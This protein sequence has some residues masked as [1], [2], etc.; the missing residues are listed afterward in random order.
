MR[1]GAPSILLLL[2]AVAGCRTERAAPPHAELLV[3]AGDSTY[4]IST[5]PQGL[6]SRGSPI[7]LARFGGRFYEVYVVD[8]DRSYT[9]AEVVAQQVWRR[10]LITNDS[11]LVFRDTTILGLER[12]YAR[13]HPD[14]RRLDPDESLGDMPHVSATSRFDLLD[15]FGPFMSYDYTADL[16]VTAGDEWHFARRG[17]LDLRDGGDASLATLFG[18]SVARSLRKE[19]S[20]LFSQ[21]LDSVL[22]SNDARAREAG[23]AAWRSLHQHQGPDGR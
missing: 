2:L 17:V 6:R 10:D 11:A 5:G 12:W 22:A 1:A 8:D 4:W 15:Q 16:I 3:A 19:G 7:Q 21:A 14:D 9:D 20:A 13:A 23:R 18:D